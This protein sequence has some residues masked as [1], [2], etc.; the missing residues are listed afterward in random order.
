MVFLTGLAAW[1]VGRWQAKL[2]RQIETA[3][4]QIRVQGENA[5]GN[6]RAKWRRG[7][8]HALS[9]AFQETVS[10]L[11]EVQNSLKAANAMLGQR[12]ETRTR[13]LNTILDISNQLASQSEITT[14]ANGIL[15]QLRQAVDFSSA[16]ISAKQEKEIAK[17][18]SVDLLGYYLPAQPNP[19]ATPVF[20][21]C[22]PAM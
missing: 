4:D 18:E 15:S 10:H 6:A 11:L 22:R 17:S 16:T 13:E 3:S 14:M 9:F 5:P 8:Q 7:G 21:I 1:Q 2:S 20:G 12:V 19:P